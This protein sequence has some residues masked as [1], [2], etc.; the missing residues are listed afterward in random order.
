[1]TEDECKLLSTE[2]AGKFVVYYSCRKTDKRTKQD[3]GKLSENITLI[4][5]EDKYVTWFKIRNLGDLDGVYLCCTY[6]S[7]PSSCR[8]MGDSV[9][10][11][12]KDVVA[13]CNNI[14]RMHRLSEDKVVN[15]NCKDL[16]NMGISNNVY[17][18]ND[19][20]G[21]NPNGQFTCHTARGESVVG[22]FLVSLE[23]LLNISNFHVKSQ[24]A[25]SDHSSL[26]L[27]LNWH[28]M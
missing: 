24:T 2:M 9:R 4:Q 13:S 22:Y 16:L 17:I 3:S 10:I 1:M 11:N 21:E 26:A 7:P 19:R 23:L 15:E 8:Y 28:Y 6:I 20:I 25:L 27:K 12:I 5:H 18:V 14:V